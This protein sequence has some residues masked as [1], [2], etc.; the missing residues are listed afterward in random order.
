ML[1][2]MLGMKPGTKLSETGALEKCQCE[3]LKGKQW[4]CSVSSGDQCHRDGDFSRAGSEESVGESHMTARQ[5][6][7]LDVQ[8]L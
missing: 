6:S 7:E 2:I 8:G 3:K 1:G 5:Q 4:T